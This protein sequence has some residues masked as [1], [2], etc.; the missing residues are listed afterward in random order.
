MLEQIIDR[1]AATH[2]RPDDDRRDAKPELLEVGVV[3]DRRRR[4]DVIVEPTVLVVR[5]HEQALAPLRRL[6]DG[7]HHTR[8]QRLAQAHVVIRVIVVR[9]ATRERGI[10]DRE[11]RQRARARILEE[12]LDRREPGELSIAAGRPRHVGVVVRALDA[13]VGEPMEDPLIAERGHV[14]LDAL[15]RRAVQIEP[16][17]PRRPEA[18]RE[19]PIAH[20]ARI[21]ERVCHRQLRAYVIAHHVG[22]ARSLVLFHEAIV[23]AAVPLRVTRSP[24]MRW[25]LGCEVIELVHGHGNVARAEVHLGAGESVDIH[26][27]LGQAQ[28]SQIV[29]ERSVLHTQDDD[30][31]DVRE[32]LLGRHRRHA[33]ARIRRRI[34]RG[35]RAG[36]RAVDST[37]GFD[38]IVVVAADDTRRCTD[39]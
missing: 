11:R 21:R 15:A 9:S 19:P 38:A 30:R 24:A 27:V 12:L 17:R 10:D 37:V 18:P 3:V 34:D 14:R 35:V 25:I 33:L 1:T 23:R 20:H 36:R 32:Q 8:D 39:A 6:R 7:R 5:E 31:L 4:A 2:R 29:I 13:R 22:L 26:A 28:R 16:V